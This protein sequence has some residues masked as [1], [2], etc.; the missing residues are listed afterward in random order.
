MAGP[1][2]RK[3]RSSDF[4]RKRKVRRKSSSKPQLAVGECGHCGREFRKTRPNHK[5][6]KTA[7]HHDFHTLRLR[8]AEAE[9]EK[10]GR[11]RREVPQVSERQLAM[12]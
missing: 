7:C 12:F 5:F 1:L 10:A 9:K 8:K 3:P 2:A 6:C 4:L 11:P